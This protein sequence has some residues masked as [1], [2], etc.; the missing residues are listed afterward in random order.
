MRTLS[1]PTALGAALAACLPAIAIAQSNVTAYGIMDLTVRYS[2]NAAAGGASLK[3][4]GDGAYTGS[5]LGFRGTEDLGGGMHAL[6]NIEQGIEPSTGTLQQTTATANYGQAAA[7]AGRAWGRVAFVGLAAPFGTVTLGRQYTLAHDMSGR[8]QPQSNPNVDALS[9]FSGHHVARQDNMVKYTH[10][11]GP[12][13]IGLTATAGERTNGSA[14]GASA[15]YTAGPFDAVAYAQEMKSFNGTETRKIHGLGGSYAVTSALKA[16]IGTMHRSHE[17]SQQK[18]K[19]WTA[20]AN[21]KV[22]EL[23]VLTASYTQDRQRGTGIGSRKVA[24]VGVDYLLSKRTDIYAEVD[25]NK[26]TGAYPLPAF[27]GTRASA[28]G[29]SVGLRHRF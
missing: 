27:M 29:G 5:R 26:L 22:T 7:P 25:N 8:F 16:F 17:L 14:W 20:G 21:L 24:F 19:V 15:S 11:L 9:V 2:R 28:T 18:N 1:M 10:R 3:S 6:F 12:V 4:V 23:L 13:G